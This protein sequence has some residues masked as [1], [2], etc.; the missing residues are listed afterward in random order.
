MEEV[1]PRSV[2]VLGLTVKNTVVSTWVVMALIVVGAW[3]VRRRAPA[4]LEMLYAFLHDLIQSTMGIADVDD[5]IPFL[6]T[7]VVF[8][9]VANNISIVP[10][11]QT[12]TKDINTTVALALIVLVSTYYFG[13]RTRGFVRY[14]KELASPM[15]VLDLIGHA[16]R[17]LSLS[18]R[19]FGNIIAGEIIVAVIYRLVKPIAPLAMMGLGLITGVLQAYVFVVIATGAIGLAVRPKGS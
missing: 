12:P 6:G 2:D 5:Y 7:M 16:S 19:L 9:V 15:L 18:L 11:I 17:T 8:L 10:L 3:L 1:F 13:F 4:A 14:L